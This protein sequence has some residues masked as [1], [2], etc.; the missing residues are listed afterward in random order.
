MGGGCDFQGSMG[1]VYEI[2]YNRS[3]IDV[4]LVSMLAHLEPVSQMMGGITSINSIPTSNSTSH[5]LPA[6]LE[7]GLTI[8]RISEINSKSQT[9]KMHYILRWMWRD[10]RLLMNCDK[11]RV[12]D[13]NAEFN[14]FWRPQVRIAEREDD[15]EAMKVERHLLLGHGWDVYTEEHVSYF[16]C[17][18]DFQDMPFDFQACT[19]TFLVPDEPD[20]TIKLLWGG[21]E[22]NELTNAEWSIT[23]PEEWTKSYTSEMFKYG[24]DFAYSSELVAEFHLKREPSYLMHTF[25]IPSL[26]F[27]LM[28][29]VGLWIDV[30][31]VPARAAV[32]VIPVLVTSNKMSALSASIP[33][34]SYPT[35]LSNFMM[36][37]L[38]IIV[39]HLFEY[40]LIHYAARRSK[41]LGK[42]MERWEQVLQDN[43]STEKSKEPSWL[44]KIEFRIVT[45]ID[46]YV[47][48]ATRFL[49]PL[50]YAILAAV[51]L[52]A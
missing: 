39:V 52:Q 17:P 37:T 8:L 20:T 29:W 44:L 45:C 12:S 49:S 19:L 38:M 35:R 47:E 28:S 3:G 1:S 24:A 13:T 26:M 25:V 46:L 11:L 7:L 5:D 36:M 15:I 51:Y 32:G 30:A 43:S 18:W 14:S 21:L 33:P 34:I 22:G 50:I 2:M 48:V 23:Q 10:C 40:G 4:V 9:Y 27:Y 42:M 16:R 6:E 31:A 41:A